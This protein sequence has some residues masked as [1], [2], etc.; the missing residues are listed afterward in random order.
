MACPKDSDE[1]VG[2][3]AIDHQFVPSG[4]VAWLGL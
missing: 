2:S 1:G 3:T 4:E